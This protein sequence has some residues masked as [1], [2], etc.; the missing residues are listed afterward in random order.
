MDKTSVSLLL[1]L[2]ASYRFI[3]WGSGLFN[4]GTKL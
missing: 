1:V 3:H 2:G 4:G